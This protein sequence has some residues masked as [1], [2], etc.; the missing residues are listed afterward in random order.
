ML[1][2]EKLK[3]K[4]EKLNPV[5]LNWC[6]E[7]N[8]WIEENPLNLTSWLSTYGLRVWT[9][10]RKEI[11]GQRKEKENPINIVLECLGGVYMYCDILISNPSFRRR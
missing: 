6:N 7:C 3:T 5:N 4:S 1:G 2:S 8:M 9:K 10:K 11:S